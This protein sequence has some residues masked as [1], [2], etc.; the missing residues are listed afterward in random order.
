MIRNSSRF[1]KAVLGET[2]C[3]TQ[4]RAN[5]G[6]PRWSVVENLPANARHRG[7]TGLI[8]GEGHGNALQDSC[9]E[10][11]KDT[12][13]WRAT[14]HGVT[15]TR[16]WLSRK[17]QPPIIRGEDV[18]QEDKLLD[19]ANVLEKTCKDQWRPSGDG[20]MWRWHS[21]GSFLH[22]VSLALRNW[23]ERKTKEKP[24]HPSPYKWADHSERAP[25]DISLPTLAEEMLRSDALTVS[26][27]ARGCGNTSRQTVGSGQKENQAD[28]AM[29]GKS[30]RFSHEFREQTLRGLE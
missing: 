16:T 10:N 23:A 26:L 25:R 19:E 24:G 22:P 2:E 1:L 18:F 30:P 5:G 17:Q 3:L 14:V 7:D 20:R 4:D 27:S 9:L 29:G 15:K 12:G 8:P 21:S 11:S 6:P 28:R 13:D